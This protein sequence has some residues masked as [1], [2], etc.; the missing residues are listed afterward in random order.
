MDLI[1]EDKRLMWDE[2]GGGDVEGHARGDGV[3]IERAAKDFLVFW[4]GNEVERYEML[5]IGDAEFVDDE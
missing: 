2:P 1:E 4:M 5:V 3:R